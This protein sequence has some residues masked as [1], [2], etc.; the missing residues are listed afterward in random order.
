MTAKDAQAV[1]EMLRKLHGANAEEFCE[2]MIAHFTQEHRLAVS[3]AW[4]R[5]LRLLA[6]SEA[7]V[8]ER[9]FFR[10]ERANPH[11]LNGASEKGA[12]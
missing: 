10:Q 4:R 6:L 7:L 11:H 5:V 3:K 9:G 8:P 2:R 12:C 1:A